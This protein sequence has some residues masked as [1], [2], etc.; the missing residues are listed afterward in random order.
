[1]ANQYTKNPQY[2][3]IKKNCPVCGDEFEAKK[4]CPKEKQTC[5]YACS[6]KYFRSGENNG[7][8]KGQNYRKICFAHHE[9]KCIVCGEELAVEVHHADGDKTNHDPK[10]LVPICPNHH[11]YY[12]S[13][14]R[15]LVESIIQEYVRV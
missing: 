8:W 3:W 13:K 6:N 4:G 12:H 9:K 7:C 5:G 2:P 15:S 10:N 1:M 14:H 11:Q